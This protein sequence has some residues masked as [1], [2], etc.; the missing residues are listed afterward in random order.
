M[1]RLLDTFLAKSSFLKGSR[2]E[3]QFSDNTVSTEYVYPQNPDERW[4]RLA[5]VVRKADLD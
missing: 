5:E 1:L 2:R 3:V 4:T